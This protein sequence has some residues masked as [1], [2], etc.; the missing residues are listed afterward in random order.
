MNL[1]N[2]LALDLGASS[3]RVLLMRFNRRKLV[4]EKV[5]QFPAGGE[6]VS[7]KL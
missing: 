4:L 2:A 3:N 1:I 5:H 7:E 6:N